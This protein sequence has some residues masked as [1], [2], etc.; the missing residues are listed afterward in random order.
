MENQVDNQEPA[1]STWSLYGMCAAASEYASNGYSYAWDAAA[2][3]TA[4]ARELASESAS[5]AYNKAMET[6]AVQMLDEAKLA[7]KKDAENSTEL[8]GRI[9]EQTSAAGK[10]TIERSTDKAL[11]IFDEVISEAVRESAGETAKSATDATYLYVMSYFHGPEDS[12]AAAP[13]NAQEQNAE[14]TPSLIEK[15]S[16]KISDRLANEAYEGIPDLVDPLVEIVQYEPEILEKPIASWLKPSVEELKSK[17]VI[18][19][20]EQKI[21]ENDGKSNGKDLN[22]KLIMNF[23][24]KKQVNKEIRLRSTELFVDKLNSDADFGE[25][26]KE[27]I[28]DD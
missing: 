8:A 9:Y 19:F 14:V 23:V 21:A 5:Y 26:I 11:K 15:I 13:A 3:R 6:S 16:S 24:K 12:Q 22:K 7:A 17:L 28:K 27:A 25:A 20:F 4:Y 10:K 1:D 2:A 18:K